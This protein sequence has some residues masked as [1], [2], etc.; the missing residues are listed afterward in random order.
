MSQ[1]DDSEMMSGVGLVYVSIFSKGLIGEM[2]GLL[3]YFCM[4]LLS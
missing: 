1:H 4:N 2:A 3:D